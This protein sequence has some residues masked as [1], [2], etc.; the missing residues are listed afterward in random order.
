[1]GLF[2]E[3]PEPDPVLVVFDENIATLAVYLRL[4]LTQW[5][6]G[7]GGLVGLDYG[8][9]SFFLELEQVPKATWPEVVNG[10]QLMELEVPRL[11]RQKDAK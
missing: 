9:L 7:P 4:H 3:Q 10:V 11:V 5:R 2:L 6:T 8:P 1:M